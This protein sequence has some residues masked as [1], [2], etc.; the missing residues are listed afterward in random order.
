ML[1]TLNF[2]RYSWKCEMLSFGRSRSLNSRYWKTVVP[3]G[4]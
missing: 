2:A 4:K 1:N 3:A